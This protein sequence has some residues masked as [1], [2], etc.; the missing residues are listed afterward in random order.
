ML[1]DSMLRQLFYNLMDNTLKYG[2]KTSTIRVHYKEEAEQLKLI[3]EDDGAGIP[4][5][6]K[7]KLFQ[8]GYEKGTGFELYLLKRIC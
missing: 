7:S 3:Y 4:G 2:E 6:E 1:A 5:E 8:E